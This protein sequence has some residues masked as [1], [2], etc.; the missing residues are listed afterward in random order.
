MKKLLIIILSVL[1]LAFT[2]ADY[3]S[4]YKVPREAA[5]VCAADID[6]DGDMDLIIGHYYSS[7][8]E[9][10][11]VSLLRNNGT[12]IFTLTDSI[13][14]FGGGGKIYSTQINMDSMPDIVG[15]HSIDESLYLA[16][17]LYENEAYNQ[18]YYQ[19]GEKINSFN[20]GNIN[21][22]IAID[23]VFISNNNQYWGILY[24]NGSGG[25]S[26]P[27]YYDL[28]YYPQDIVAGDLNNDGADDIVIGGNTEIY[29]STDGSFQNLQ[30]GAHTSRVHIGDIDNDGD[31]DI[32]GLYDLLGAET[33][34]TIFE[35]KGQ[36]AFELHEVTGYLPGSIYSVLTDFNNDT[37]PDLMVLP[38]SNDGVYILYNIGG[39]AYQEPEFIEIANEG[40]AYRR[41]TSADMD[42][43]GY[44]DIV[45]VRRTG[46]NADTFNNVII[47]FN[48]G[49][50]NFVENPLGVEE[51]YS[52]NEKIEFINF[53]NPFSIE[54]TFEF[55]L[56]ETSHIELSV[57]N[58]KGKLVKS[59]INNTIIGG[60]NQIKWNGLNN[61]SQACE[62]GLYIAS[63]K[64]NGTIQQT[65]KLLKQL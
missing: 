43:N 62:P 46:P 16:V 38:A 40:E 32:I 51:N 12:G 42:G 57:Y 15:L 48:D 8:T 59:L 64:I 11:G 9:W 31:N 1:L 5:S 50:G 26:S 61:A 52:N 58:L 23:I 22:D 55:T 44:N 35:N 65:V 25:F 49:N 28:G 45:I 17:L 53:P 27:V 4:M 34:I 7:Q 21:N 41:S 33:Q 14:I 3:R 19:L 18:K 13:F 60:K 39:F 30:L 29:F 36:E 37:L 2:T 6:L 56:K 10:S 24:N 20:I 47:L 54:T 63:L